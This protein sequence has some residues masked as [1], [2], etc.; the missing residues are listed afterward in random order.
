VVATYV[1]DCKQHLLLQRT[2]LSG[3]RN[4]RTSAVE[5]SYLPNLGNSL[6]FIAVQV[7]SQKHTL[8][9]G[10][11]MTTTIHDQSWRAP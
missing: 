3:H 5:C 9:L 6:H 1:A 8:W 4:T 7:G 11:W 10:L 2:S